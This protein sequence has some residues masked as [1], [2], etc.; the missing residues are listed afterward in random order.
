ME[1]Y[2]LPS[3]PGSPRVWHTLT[4]NVICGGV[5]PGTSN[6]CLA[7][8]TEKGWQELEM[9]LE[10]PRL[11]HSS[12]LSP[13]GIVLLGGYSSGQST[14]TLSSSGSKSSFDL[15]DNTRWGFIIL[16]RFSTD[17]FPAMPAP[18]VMEMRL[19]SLEGSVTEKPSRCIP[20]PALKGISLTS[21]LVDSIT[22]V[23]AIRMRITKK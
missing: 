13:Q 15:Q 9:T 5:Y 2:P 6:T 10:K 21:V 19:F 20:C 8:T 11:A 3:I 12:W 7:L 16:T 1:T 17:C 18:S 14:E 22:P 4:D 23:P